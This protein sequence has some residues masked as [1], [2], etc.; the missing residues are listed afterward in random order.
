MQTNSTS[1][2]FGASLSSQRQFV[3]TGNDN[4]S[5]G[6]ETSAIQASKLRMETPRSN[7]TNSLPAERWTNSGQHST[8]S[9]GEELMFGNAGA[10]SL[11]K[12]KGNMSLARSQLAMAATTQRP[13]T[14]VPSHT[15]KPLPPQ[16]SAKP[17]AMKVNKVSPGYRTI[18]NTDCVSHNRTIGTGSSTMDTSCSQGVIDRQKRRQQST[19]RHCWRGQSSPHDL[20]V[21]IKR[22]IIPRH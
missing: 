14:S 18:R 21:E 17:P 1:R 10:L 7:A 9:T 2:G 19:Q 16:A 12:P 22:R 8:P 4:D 6:S 11:P 5:S 13:T 15:R 20:F 3:A